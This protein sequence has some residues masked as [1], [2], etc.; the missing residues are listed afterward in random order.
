MP[1]LKAVALYGAI[2]VTTIGGLASGFG[3]ALSYSGE[4]NDL[5]ELRRKELAAV[6]RK[7][8]GTETLDQVIRNHGLVISGENRLD[9][10]ATAYVSGT[11]ARACIEDQFANTPV[12]QEYNN[13]VKAHE[14]AAA[15]YDWVIRASFAS[16]ATALVGAVTGR[17]ATSLQRKQR[18]QQSQS[19]EP[20]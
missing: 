19:H 15:R 14:E 11:V 1:S 3:F 5:N 6:V 17:I 9:S 7:Y 12:C 8:E 18:Y 20:S 10:R 2:A 16:L 13:A 4:K